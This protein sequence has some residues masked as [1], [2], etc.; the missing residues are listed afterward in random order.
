MSYSSLIKCGLSLWVKSLRTILPLPFLYCVTLLLTRRRVCW[1]VSIISAK[2]VV[3]RQ[4]QM[5]VRY[6]P[7]MAVQCIPDILHSFSYSYSTKMSY[8]SLIKRGL[9]LLWVQSPRTILPLPF[10]YCI[11]LLLTRRKLCWDVSIISAKCVVSRQTQMMVRYKPALAVL[12]IPDIL[13]SFSNSYSTKMSYSS[14]MKYGL[15]LWVKSLRTILP[16]PF[17]YCIT[18]LLTR[19]KLCWEVSIISAKCVVSRQT[20][21]MVRYKPVMAVQCIPD[22]LHSFS[23]SYSTKMSYSSLMKCGLSLL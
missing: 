19:R 2:C 12:C 16:L 7:V 14:L 6:K 23:T 3:S 8:S 1:K 17:L 10:L 15:S 11:T 9:S 13:H 22:I 18:L 20:Q 5:M 21:M 4:T